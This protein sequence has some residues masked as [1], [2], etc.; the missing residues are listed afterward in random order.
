M[1]IPLISIITVVYN[2]RDLLEKTIQ[3]VANQCYRPFEYIVVDGNSTDGTIDIIKKYETEISTW[4]SEKDTGIYN[5]MNKAVG[6]TN[7]EWIFFLNAG[8]LFV[9]EYVLE[10]ISPY[11]TDNENDVVYGD[12][13]KQDKSGALFVKKS[14]PPGDKHKMYFCHQSVFCRTKICREMPFDETY[15]LSADFKFFKLAFLKGFRFKQIDLPITIFDTTGASHQNRIKGLL[16]NIKIIKETNHLARK[17]KLLPRLY[18]VVVFAK[19]RQW[20][21]K[22]G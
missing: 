14:T 3:T 13:L 9:N 11:L 6:L 16:E 19:L 20:L 5:A 4:I 1:N 22:K 10:K 17:I 8:D 18:F 12:I 15:S 7:G 21:K 2:N